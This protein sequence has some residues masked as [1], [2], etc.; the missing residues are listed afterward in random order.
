MRVMVLVKA[1]P[2]SEAGA[3]PSTELLTA[4]GA[5]NEALVQ[6]GILLAGE[7]LQPSGAGKR[8][9]FASGEPTVVDG[10]FAETT[11]LVAGFW[12]WQVRSM[13]EAV[14]WARRCPAPMPSGG[15]LELRPV[16]EADDFG[17]EL[18]PELRRQ[19]TL[20]REQAASR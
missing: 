19:E 17:P 9:R 3:M 10:P 18:T 15:E 5:Y 4:M 6:A 7:G 14:E 1:T 16:F 12:L 8:V 20:L 11:A 2:D 13:E